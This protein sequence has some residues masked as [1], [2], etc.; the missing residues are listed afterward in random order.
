M[1]LI[2]KEW[3]NRRDCKITI[4]CENCGEVRK[5]YPA[6]DDR[7]FW[8]NVLPNLECENCGKSTKEIDP[9]I[10]QKIKTKHPEGKQL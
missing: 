10:K 2:K 8:D 4:K 5:N 9:E 1:K 6:Y 7:N 3:Q